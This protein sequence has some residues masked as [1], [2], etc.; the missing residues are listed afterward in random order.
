MYKAIIADDE[1]K[2]CQLILAMGRWEEL[3]ICVVDICHS[4]D[5]TWESIQ[6]NNPDI[7][8]TDIRMP[9][10]D[11]LQIINKYNETYGVDGRN[12]CFIII[13][14]Y[15]EFE[16]ARQAIQYNI[17]NYLLKPLDREQLNETLRKACNS[18][19]AKQ[20]QEENA[21]RLEENRKALQAECVQ[22]L[23]RIKSS[24][25][26][27]EINQRYCTHFQ[28][29]RYR[30]LF[31]NF[32]FSISKQENLF[33]KIF[34]DK[35]NEYL[36]TCC[37]K[38]LEA[39]GTGIY[40]LLNYSD[41][42]SN[43]REVIGEFYKSIGELSKA[44]GEF[45][46][47]LG[48]GGEKDDIQKAGITLEEA[49]NAELS[50]ILHEGKSLVF[51]EDLEKDQ[52]SL[53]QVVSLQNFRELEQILEKLSIF[54]IK[55][56]FSHAAMA[57]EKSRN[58]LH[59]GI[60]LTDVRKVIFG[61][62]RKTLA[63]MDGELVDQKLEETERA[64]KQAQNLSNY[65]WILKSKTVLLVEQ[66]T[67][68]ISQREIHPV[69]AAKQYIQQ[70]YGKAITL[71]EIAEKLNFS[72]VYFGN[73]FKKHTGKTFNAYLTDVRMDQAKQLLKKQEYSISQIAGMVGYQDIK[74]FS[75]TFKNVY[76]VKPSEYRKLLSSL[77]IEDLHI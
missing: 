36:G 28:Q 17:V 42:L 26:M 4:G 32:P 33:L 6:K 16:Y 53:Y 58:R 12:I 20:R 74:Y 46:V 9:V 18:L 25:D 31:L 77:H 75:R 23:R 76:G 67:E 3:G 65:F 29:G 63:E 50:R 22:S 49:E 8:L 35:L 71:S 15:A 43:M 39:D 24:G 73:M 62:I 40:V 30:G 47:Y 60:I 72:S 19:E 37:E 56:W 68:L 41:D 1:N 13:S 55:N 52:E 59:T 57:F 64:L 27:A 51:Y 61:I 69:Q 66:L 54:E 70:N 34:T 45:Q 5:D 38:I 10:L 11:G 2:I 48:V 44:Y 21:Q 7:V 14:G